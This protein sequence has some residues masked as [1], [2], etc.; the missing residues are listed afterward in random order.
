M[1]AIKFKA[2]APRLPSIPIW[3][4]IVGLLMGTLVVAQLTTLALALALPL[5]PPPQ[6]RL[7]EIAGALRGGALASPGT[8]PLQRSYQ[9]QPPSSQSIGWLPFERARFDLAHMLGVDPSDVRLLFYSPPP[10]AGFPAP[11]GG[12]HERPFSPHG[13]P[14][15][16][17]PDGGGHIV[18][19]SI[20]GP[21]LLAPMGGPG[22]G[23][24]GGPG[25]GWPGGGFPGRGFPG[26]G[27]GGSI[28]GGGG[29]YPPG[30]DGGH[31]D[32]PITPVV[33]GAPDGS[34]GSDGASLPGGASPDGPVQTAPPPPQT[35][36]VRP[37]PVAASD[38][39]AARQQARAPAATAPVAPIAVGALALPPP[40][41]AYV[42]SATGSA[43]RALKDTEESQP[44]AAQL[45]PPEARGLFGFNHP[46]SVYGEF[47]A[48]LRVGPNRW[49]IV[50]PVRSALLSRW[51]RRM[52]LWFL[53]S[54]AAVAPIGYLFARRLAAPL[55]RLADAADRLGRDP[56]GAPPKGGGSIEIDRVAAAFA[57]MQAR[58]RRYVD[59]R[60]AMVGAISH[61]LRTPLARMRFRLERVSEPVRTNMLGDIGQMEEM[62]N[63]VLTFIRDASEPG[64][65]ERVDLRSI[66]ECVVDDAALVGGDALLASGETAPVEVD[67]LSVQRLMTNLIENALKYG[68]QAR[69]RLFV[70]GAD[71]VIEIAD[72]GPGLP[73][74]ELERVFLPF[75]RSSESRT[76]NAS[77]IGLGLSVSRSIA[78]AHGGDVTL[79]RGPSGLIAQI[80][81]PLA[82]RPNTPR[83]RNEIEDHEPPMEPVRLTA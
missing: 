10:F 31:L 30:G 3:A 61:D 35:R 2:A 46:P 18:S 38:G 34:G 5:P 73:D 24:P 66:L 14:D 4:Q 20:F 13:P 68:Q 80:R 39:D 70:D 8:P 47:V 54:C 19:G 12:F 50:R 59:D 82:V 25:G 53:L 36:A 37:P 67:I 41:A 9:T 63:A 27:S 1:I 64:H 26:R 69:A 28:P 71:A 48:A 40:R 7:H 58:L 55:A 75:Y 60:T 11:P 81:L 76:L 57:G 17:G 62:I 51:Q 49:E 72:D 56:S 77:G 21:L 45:P 65:R 29:G 32:P 6:F 15:G 78:R 16:P 43:G 52:A 23:G 42:P 22:G 33:V 79:R 44:L 83:A 74:S